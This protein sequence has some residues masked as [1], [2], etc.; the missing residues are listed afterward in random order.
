M[1]V[2]FLSDSCGPW[3]GGPVHLSNQLSS[4]AA[5]SDDGEVIGCWHK[6]DTATSVKLAITTFEDRP[7]LGPFVLREL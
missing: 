3:G 2:V 6:P 1:K 4:M 5:I 7:Q